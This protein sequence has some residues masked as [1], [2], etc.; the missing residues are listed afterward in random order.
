MPTDD[1]GKVPTTAAPNSSLVARPLPEPPSP[2]TTN[3]NTHPADDNKKTRSD[4]GF[5][6]TSAVSVTLRCRRRPPNA[7]TAARAPSRGERLQVRQGALVDGAQQGGGLRDDGEGAP[8]RAAPGG[9]RVAEGDGVGR[10][11]GSQQE[12]GF[13]AREHVARVGLDVCACVCS[14][15]HAWLC[16]ALR[17][18]NASPGREGGS[19]IDWYDDIRYYPRVWQRT[20]E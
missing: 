12:E 19:G 6:S 20:G 17:I 10:A 9:Y 7:R 4:L 11:S 5:A 16:C 15:R 13:I 2:P 1:S 14:I 8:G 18:R 3:N